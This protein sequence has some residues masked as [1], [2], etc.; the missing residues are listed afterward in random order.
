MWCVLYII[1]SKQFH[2]VIGMVST[3]YMLL[4]TIPLVILI[5]T[6]KLP[7]KAYNQHT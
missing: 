3:K 1:Y 5:K 2:I 6:D 4:T 7:V